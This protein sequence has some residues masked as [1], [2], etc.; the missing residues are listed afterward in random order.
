MYGMKHDLDD[1]HIFFWA[2]RTTKPKFELSSSSWVMFYLE[3]YVINLWLAL[4]FNNWGN[5]VKVHHIIKYNENR[6]QFT[7]INVKCIFY[8]KLIK[9]MHFLFIKTKLP[10]MN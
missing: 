4:I 1:H 10:L 8:I 7:H 6:S 9:S 5:D 3:I 2:R